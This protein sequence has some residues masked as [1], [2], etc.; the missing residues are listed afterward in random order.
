MRLV[1]YS[2]EASFKGLSLFNQTKPETLTVDDSLVRPGTCLCVFHKRDH[3][4]SQV[5]FCRQP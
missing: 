2:P 1:C 4:P 5:T 3:D